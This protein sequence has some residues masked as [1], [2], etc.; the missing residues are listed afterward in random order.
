MVATLDQAP[1][2]SNHLS[3]HASQTLSDASETDSSLSQ[4]QEPHEAT[5][6]I[7]DQAPSSS[8]QFSKKFW[9]TLEDFLQHY[10]T[11]LSPETKAIL[12]NKT[13]KRLFRQ[14]PKAINSTQ[15]TTQE[16]QLAIV[17]EML[18]DY[19]A[20]ADLVEQA[21]ATLTES[22]VNQWEQTIY[23]LLV[24]TTFQ[25]AYKL[26]PE[27]IA[28]SIAQSA[29]QANFAGNKDT[30]LA[31]YQAVMAT[32]QSLS[33][34]LSHEERPIA[35]WQQVQVTQWAQK[36][37]KA[38][39]K[40]SQKEMLAVIQRAVELHHGFLP[41]ATQ[42]LSVLAL[43]NPAKDTGRLAQIN[44]GEGKSLIV[45]MLAAVHALQGQYVDVITTSSELAIPEVLKQEH[46]FKML[47]LTVGE[48][49]S[50]GK[51]D[52]AKAAVYK[53]DI[54]Y[55]TAEDFQADILR[56]SIRDNRKFGVAIV[57]EVDSLLFDNRSYS[58]RLS[59]PM[60]GMEHLV[61]ALLIIRRLVNNIG[62]PENKVRFDEQGSFSKEQVQSKLEIL[63]R[64][65]S[66]DEC[67]QLKDYEKREMDIC[68]LARKMAEASDEQRPELEAQLQEAAEA[69]KATPW[70]Q[71]KEYLAVPL[72]LQEF[73]R[74]QIPHW[75]D[76]AILARFHYKKDQQYAVVKG[77]IVPIDC[78]NTGELQYSTVWSDGLLQFLQ[79]KE[80]LR[81]RAEQVATNFISTVG[82]FKRYQG[83][84]YGVT[85]TLGNPET[86][87]FLS[88][89][90]ETD[91]VVV[92]PYKKRQIVG[93]TH[94]TYHCKELRPRILSTKERW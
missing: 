87:K 35:Q 65:L 21:L 23:Q 4:P 13:C 29:L 37:K 72:H 49:S 47:S 84:L 73:A 68:E 19:Q 82:Y 63:L 9:Q 38:P 93:N 71:A 78:E 1:F 34:I 53:K 40:V 55:G 80:G 41:R 24:D 6:A 83:R 61:P 48:N 3:I 69:L 79:I 12:T 39:N 86:R 42:M 5:V 56:Q 60:P 77:E 31:S 50:H 2:S 10:P 70:K 25:D 91:M 94:S 18:S 30:L 7:L 64:T 43:L 46:F 57:D 81:I 62:V 15:W 75:I 22:P 20:T 8:S 27:A 88:K 32:Y 11:D 54:V 44:T 33:S 51:S 76:S 28:A 90:Y 58:T 45:A 14:L 16:K 92:P 52:A 17:L 66:P 89:V 59:S 85:G 26:T 36:V 67:E 74:S